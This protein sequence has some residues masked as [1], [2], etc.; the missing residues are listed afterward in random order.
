MEVAS[1]CL[2]LPSFIISYPSAEL[3]IKKYLNHMLYL[4]RT[5]LLNQLRFPDINTMQNILQIQR[6]PGL[7][8]R[9]NVSTEIA[10]EF[11]FSV[12][13]NGRPVSHSGIISDLSYISSNPRP[14]TSL[15]PRLSVDG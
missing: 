5:Q 7:H 8:E 3:L 1:K 2:V 12:L 6:F 15:F 13:M 11:L 10:I 14:H 4:L 9:L